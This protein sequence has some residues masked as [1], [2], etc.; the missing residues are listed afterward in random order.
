M[1]L[2]KNINRIMIAGT[3]SGCGKTTIVCG[4]LG[5]LKKKGVIPISFKC[6]PDYIDPMFHRKIIEVDSY[7]LDVF[8][9]GENSIKNLLCVTSNEN[10]ISLI[11]GVMGFYDGL[12]IN[13]CYS[14]SFHISD[15][16][17]TN[18]IIVID[19]GKSA[20]SA[21]AVLKGFKEFR[22]NNIS[23]CIL[24]NVS[25]KNYSIY[26]DMIESNT[27]VPVL[28]FM[29]KDKNIEISSRHLGLMTP[30]TI[31]DID[32]KIKNIIDYSCKYIDI[33]KIINLSKN[34][35]AITYEYNKNEIFNKYKIRI[36]LAYDNAFCFYYKESLTVLENMGA[37]IIYFS[38]LND[39][40][41][42]DNINA[43]FLGGGY[44]ELYADIL[45][46]N[47][48]MLESI[49]NAYKKK[50]IIIAECGGFMYLHEKMCGFDMVGII[51]GNSFM[52]NKLIRFGYVELFSKYDN[53]ISKKGEMIK[54]H[55]FHY[56]DSSNTGN[57]FKAEKSN[58]TSWECIHIKENL[59]SGYPHINFWGN[60]S[61]AER[62]IKKMKSNHI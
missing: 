56:S 59:F 6:G 58:G 62:L 46:K 23:G 31:K 29:P 1:N 2:K 12:G 38:P 28:G 41:L 35:N 40:K 47:T 44:P 4:I 52:T 42:P 48:A 37:E 30:E 61:F 57:G 54:A 18:V 25:E 53:I 11:E 14:S 24:N 55:E 51:K 43:V 15:I 8:M 10:T 20:I 17:D 32:E 19:C 50:I 60:F 34:S 16:T 36:A 33:D 45:S 22:K 21:A 39:S 5:A 7:N 49:K 3:N 27:G 26:K 13:S 9:M